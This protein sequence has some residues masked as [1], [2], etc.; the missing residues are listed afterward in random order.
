MMKIWLS[1][2]AMIQQKGGFIFF[3]DSDKMVKNE[4]ANRS[5]AKRYLG[6]LC[7]LF[8]VLLV[9]VYPVFASPSLPSTLYFEDNKLVTIEN[10]HFSPDSTLLSLSGWGYLTLT[11]IK[12]SIGELSFTGLSALESGK[13]LKIGSPYTLSLNRFK[14]TSD[15]RI[16]GP[17]DGKLFSIPKGTIE[18]LIP[19]LNATLSLSFQNLSLSDWGE[20]EAESLVLT[21]KPLT[22]ENLVGLPG[23]ALKIDGVTGKIQNGNPDLSISGSLNFSGQEIPVEISYPG[24]VVNLPEWKYTFRGRE[25]SV[26][27]STLD[28]S[29]SGGIVNQEVDAS[30]QGI[31][32]AQGDYKLDGTGITV[33]DCYIDARGFTG[34]IAGTSRNEEFMNI[35]YEKLSVEIDIRHNKDIKNFIRVE[36]CKFPYFKSPITLTGT[37]D[38]NGYNLNVEASEDLAVKYEPLGLSAKI[39]RGQF[40]QTE[41]KYV[42]WL[43]GAIS[44]EHSGLPTGVLTFHNLGIDTEGN[45]VLPQAGLEVESPAP[46]DFANLFKCNVSSL[47]IQSDSSK[48]LKLLLNGELSLGAD[49][50][51]NGNISFK[52]LSIT[53]GP[54]VNLSGVSAD[55]SLKGVAR[56]SGALDKKKE[57]GKDCL[58]GKASFY[59]FGASTPLGAEF[60]FKIYSYRSWAV[61]GGGNIPPINIPNTPLFIYKFQGGVGRNVEKKEGNK[62]F[63]MD[64][65]RSSESK[66]NWLFMAG[67]GICTVPP[68]LLDCNPL[69][70]TVGFPQLSFSLYGECTIIKGPKVTASIEFQP[71][72][73]VFRFTSLTSLDIYDVINLQGGM[74]VFA[75]YK[76]GKRG[77]YLDID[78]DFS[79]LKGRIYGRYGLYGSAWGKDDIQI[80]AYAAAGLDVSIFR[81]N[82]EGGFDFLTNKDP[83]LSGYV[84]ADGEIDLKVGAVG[85]S[86]NLQ[87]DVYKKPELDYDGTVTGYV[88]IFGEKAG[89]SK[90]IKGDL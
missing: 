81:G 32:I 87:V 5:Q 24:L 77:V 38:E 73:P 50:P 88:K 3:M 72:K 8:L 36:N 75:G 42:L 76:D 22:L 67:T 39:T 84:N 31:Y 37:V 68:D 46:L 53:E 63:T 9:G 60:W 85:A 16:L 48:K 2:G 74:E 70:L 40:F 20:I 33:K 15:E 66:D 44:F 12:K 62:P 86:G 25:I 56:I 35:S 41:G 13:I 26:S 80:K 6:V 1:K 17:S 55:F 90:H 83:F 58:S 52:E 34:R 78:S 43:D 21:A 10:C 69:Q 29:R 47:K 54:E 27:N 11:R 71:L 23:F 59:L 30:W 82:I 51:L 14:I 28:L 89:I 18:L 57:D 61:A 45:F 65:I 79:M 4:I 7:F 64:N 49:I 19:E